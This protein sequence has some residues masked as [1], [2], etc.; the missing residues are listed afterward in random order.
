ML[1]SCHAPNSTTWSKVAVG[2]PS[3]SKEGDPTMVMH[4]ASI[5][6]SRWHKMLWKTVGIFDWSRVE[7]FD[8]ND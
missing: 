1:S 3:G 5:K 8:L 4:K 6:E 7:E 2:I